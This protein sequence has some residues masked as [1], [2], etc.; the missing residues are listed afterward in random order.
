M[1]GGFFLRWKHIESAHIKK[2]INCPYTIL[3]WNH[4]LS[5]ITQPLT[6]KS[7]IEWSFKSEIQVVKSVKNLQAHP[8]RQKHTW[9]NS[10]MAAQRTITFSSLC[11]K[12]F[13]E[14]KCFRENVNY[15][16]HLK[17]HS[18]RSLSAWLKE[19]TISVVKSVSWQTDT[20][21]LSDFKRTHNKS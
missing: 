2:T 5:S 6:W 11:V 10:N 15:V 21:T 19:M 9:R 18:G 16:T 8:L 13:S 17:R 1:R 20:R 7:A 3:C 12:C 4:G 14:T